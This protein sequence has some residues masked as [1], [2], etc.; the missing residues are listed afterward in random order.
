ML[1]GNNELNNSNNSDDELQNIEAIDNA[2]VKIIDMTASIV[3]NGISNAIIELENDNK[4]RNF[5]ELKSCELVKINEAIE[6]WG[7]HK[8][9]LAPKYKPSPDEVK[10]IYDLLH[11][12]KPIS[13]VIFDLITKNKAKANNYQNFII[14][15]PIFNF[16]S[17]YYRKQTEQFIYDLKASCLKIDKLFKKLHFTKI[18]TEIFHLFVAKTASILFYLGF[19]DAIEHSG[20][21]ARK[22][23]LESYRHNKSRIE[24]LQSAMGGWIHDPKLPGK[25]SWNNLSTHPIIASAIALDVLTQPDFLNKIELCLKHYN[26]NNHITLNLE[27]FVKGIVEAVAINNDSKFVLD[28]AILIRPKWA[29]GMPETGGVIDQ[30]SSMSYEDLLALGINYDSDDLAHEI[31]DIA[32]NRFYAPSNMIKP[33][34]FNQDVL[35]VLKKIQIETG[36]KGIYFEAFFKICQK[37]G[38]K[39]DFLNTQSILTTFDQIILGE[40]SNEKEFLTDISTMLKEFHNT[41]GDAFI[42]TKISADKLF[43][44]QDELKFAPCAASAIAIADRLLLS[45]TKI[46]EAGTQKTVLERLESFMNSFTDNIKTLHRSS[47]IKDRKSVV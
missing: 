5:D 20:H 32:I 35:K 10:A 2:S 37:L 33:A 19:A 36:L 8:N 12:N 28:N 17:E 34:P 15:E 31:T 13:T 4:V 30:V 45:P 1:E 24:M 22:C 39:Y 16:D 43:S 9:I 29:P 27:S 21:V 42:L 47:Q 40:I 11:Y 26:A 41:E 38:S 25:F 6:G 3:K 7:V 46:I 44:H 14:N 18:E 23:V